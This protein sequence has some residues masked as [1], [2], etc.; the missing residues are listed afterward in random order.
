[1]VIYVVYSA[2]MVCWL[3]LAGFALMGGIG[4]LNEDGRTYVFFP[5]ELAIYG[6][7]AYSKCEAQAAREELKYTLRNGGKR[8]K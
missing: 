5:E 8:D 3:E 4:V 2:L 7:E 1:M 6:K